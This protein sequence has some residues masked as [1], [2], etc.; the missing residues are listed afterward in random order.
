MPIFKSAKLAK[1]LIALIVPPMKMS[2]MFVLILSKKW[3]AIAL[4]Y[5]MKN[6]QKTHAHPITDP[7][8]IGALRIY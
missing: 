2:A 5:A 4:L 1:Y 6:V 7:I 8:A 3:I